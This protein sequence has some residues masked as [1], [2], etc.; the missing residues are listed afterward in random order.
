MKIEKEWEERGSYRDWALG[1]LGTEN[2]RGK[3]VHF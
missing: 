3:W 1:Y 2:E